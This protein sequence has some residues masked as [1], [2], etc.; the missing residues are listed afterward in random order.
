[1]IQNIK[2]FFDTR[3]KILLASLSAD[4]LDWLAIIFLHAS[5]IPTYLM[6]LAGYT[7][8]MPSLDIALIIWTTLA[9]LFL[10]ALVQKNLANIFSIGLGFII[11]LFFVGF[12]FFA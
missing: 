2:N 12:I 8:H 9:L 10:K 7:D 1:M 6:L 11:Q 4:L 3:T 5:F